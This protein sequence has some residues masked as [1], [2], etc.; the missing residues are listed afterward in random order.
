MLS[1]ILGLETS[2]FKSFIYVVVLASV[3]TVFG[4]AVYLL[5]VGTPMAVN[6]FVGK[7]KE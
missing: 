6:Y 7:N 4:S 1:W 2:F 5:M 3:L